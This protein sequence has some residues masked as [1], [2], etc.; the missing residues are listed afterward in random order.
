MPDLFTLFFKR[1]VHAMKGIPGP[2]PRFPVGNLTEFIGGGWP[3][4]VCARLG[5]EYGGLTRLWLF[6]SPGQRRR[7]AGGHR[8]WTGQPA[9]KYDLRHIN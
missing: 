3:W 9:E 1:R 4:E 7:F 2:R 8:G 6:G 5:G